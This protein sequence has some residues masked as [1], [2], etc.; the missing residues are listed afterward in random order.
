[1]DAKTQSPWTD[2]RGRLRE[3]WQRFDDADLSRIERD[4]SSLGGILQQRYGLT[5]EAAEQQA[6]AFLHAVAVEARNHSGRSPWENPVAV[7]AGHLVAGGAPGD[8][9]R[10]PA[11]AVNGGTPP[12]GEVD[13]GGD[14]D[15]DEARGSGR[16]TDADE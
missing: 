14:K 10:L 7:P 5:R 11:Q 4:R 2:L 13:G 1:M 16:S 9:Q 8:P 15:N 12:G 3:H 6:V